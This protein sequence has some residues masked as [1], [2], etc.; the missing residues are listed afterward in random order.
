VPSPGPR[1]A[2]SQRGPAAGRLL[3]PLLRG[4][5]PRWLARVADD[6]RA[7]PN[8]GPCPGRGDVTAGLRGGPAGTPPPA[9]GWDTRRGPHESPSRDAD[10]SPGLGRA[11][12]WPYP[13]SS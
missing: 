5:A 9:N 12:A 11:S 10:P 1:A 8:L 13:T 2:V 3:S 6:V 4:R 7:G